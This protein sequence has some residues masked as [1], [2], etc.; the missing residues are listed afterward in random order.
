MRGGYA[1]A[2]A[3]RA[4]PAS[5][6]PCATCRCPPS[7]CVQT[8]VSSAPRCARAFGEKATVVNLRA[9]APSAHCAK[10][11]TPAR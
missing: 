10:V 8:A 7:P 3:A 2:A 1:A 5:S 11:T 9:G 4:L 6:L